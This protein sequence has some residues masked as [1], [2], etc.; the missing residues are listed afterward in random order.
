VSDI[1][2]S[3]PFPLPD[4]PQDVADFVRALRALKLWAGDPSLDV[5][6]RRTGVAKSTLSDAFNPQRRRT[7]SLDLVRV[8]VSACGANPAEVAAW[9]RAWRLLRERTDS[10][11]ASASPRP[12]PRSQPSQDRSST[13]RPSEGALVSPGQDAWVPRELPPDVPGFVGRGAALIALADRPGRA[14]ATVITGTAGVGKT[15]LAVHWAHEII[16]RYPDGQLYL[17]LRGHAGDPAISPSVALSLLLQSLGVSGER[18]PVDLHLQMGLYRSVLAARRV[19]IV[20]DN[21]VDVAHVRPLLPSGPHCH[22]LI[23]SRDA[24]TGLVVREGAARI[25]LDTL[26]AVESLELL[27]THLGADRVAAEPDATAE[28]AGLCAHLP[29][30]LR[31][32]AANLAARPSQTIAGTVRELRGL[33]RLGHLNVVGDPESA[34]AA[35]FDMSYRSLPTKAQQLFRLI[36]LV[37]GPEVDR[38]ATAILLGRDSAD[39]V[40]ELDELISA[41]LLFEPSPG[42]H[43]SHDL[44]ALYA[45]RHAAHEPEPLRE[46]ALHRLLSWYLLNTDAAARILVSPF[47]FDDRAELKLSGVARDFSGPAEARAWLEAELPNLTMA[48]THTAEHGPAPF[49]WH[50][51]N[52]LNG[53]LHT[54]ALGVQQLAVAG[55]ALRAAVANDDVKGQGMCH[56]ALGLATITLGDLQAALAEFDSALQCFTR[57]QHPSGILFAVGDLGYCWLRVGDI[58]RALHYFQEALERQPTMTRMSYVALIH[59]AIGHRIR[60]Q[61]A[62][63]LR[64]DSECLAYG[65][66]TGDRRMAYLAKSGL[67]MTHLDLGDPVTAEPLFLDANSTAVEFGREVDAFDDLAGLVLICVRTGRIGEAFTWMALLR[68]LVDRGVSSHAGDDWAH[69]A[70]LE[71]HLAAGLLDEGLA[72]GV[73]ALQEYDRA[74]HRLTAMRVRIRL[75][76]IHAAQ[77]NNEDARRYWESALPYTIEQSLPDRAVIEALLAGLA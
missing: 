55:T 67:A 59:L 76:R 44:L 74:G 43:R 9:D 77:G 21:V 28:L 4:D 64:L 34:V 45:R 72:I 65:E 20:L 47:A 58:G 36:G 26:T 61:H 39:P 15:A 11:A 48:V 68:E 27:A 31:I 29:L 75:G 35:A 66:R 19:L 51:A 52:S 24:L 32:S 42:R 62:E 63:A 2:V 33:D 10:A 57:I 17:D 16:E 7:P 18:I 70:I 56:L 8:I 60:G 6:R 54:R 13:P 1:G 41:H 23:T 38:E 53:H 50:L 71:A 49:A 25:T 69:T 3:G 14:P 37:P 5:L 46:A 73:P 12:V 30:A 22:A 40:P